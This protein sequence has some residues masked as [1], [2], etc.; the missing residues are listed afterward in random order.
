MTK[1]KHSFE[2]YIFYRKKLRK[3]NSNFSDCKLDPVPGPNTLFL[4]VDPRI[5]IHINMKRIRNTGQR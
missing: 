3:L 1:K 4:E 5:R 2:Y